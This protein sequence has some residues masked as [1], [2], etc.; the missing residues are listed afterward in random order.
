[1]QVWAL[2]RDCGGG[3]P[4]CSVRHRVQAVSGSNNC[5]IWMLWVSCAAAVAVVRMGMCFEALGELFL[6]ESL[7]LRADHRGGQN[8]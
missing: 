2:I 1:M 8:Y 3:S 7:S 5:S 6:G 4:F